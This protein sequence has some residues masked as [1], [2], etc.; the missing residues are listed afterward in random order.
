[1]LA[2]EHQNRF[3]ELETRILDL[4]KLEGP[5]YSVE[6]QHHYRE[7]EQ[8][9]HNLKQMSGPVRQVYQGYFNQEY[10]FSK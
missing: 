3:A 10:F 1:V 4:K 5:V 7:I 2:V 8:Q 6:H 9:I